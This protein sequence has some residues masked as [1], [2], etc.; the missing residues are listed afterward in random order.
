M[1]FRDYCSLIAKS[2][3]ETGYDSFYPSACVPG[4]IKDKFHVLDGEL[5]EIGEECV[6]LTWAESLPTSSGKVFLAFRGGKRR[7]TV[8]ELKGKAVLDSLVIQVNPYSE[9]AK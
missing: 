5:T 3:A 9:D 6:A 1:K 4:F 8:L 2:V 7:V